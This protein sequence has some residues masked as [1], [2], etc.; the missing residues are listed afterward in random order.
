MSPVHAQTHWVAWW[1]LEP[2]ASAEGDSGPLLL[3]WI[4]L[5]WPLKPVE[6]S[7]F[8]NWSLKNQGFA[9]FC[10]LLETDNVVWTSLPLWENFLRTPM[11]QTNTRGR[12][13]QDLRALARTLKNLDFDLCWTYTDKLSRSCY[14]T[15][16][17]LSCC[18]GIAVTAG[19]K[20]FDLWRFKHWNLWFWAVFRDRS[21][22]NFGSTVKTDH[23]PLA[24]SRQSAFR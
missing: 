24:H 1:G 8:D 21:R 13:A 14:T 4:A 7:C 16:A 12:S 10:P 20:L 23:P 5:C 19:S 15:E 18:M 6:Y 9:D 11:V 22:R 2:W 17:G 3:A